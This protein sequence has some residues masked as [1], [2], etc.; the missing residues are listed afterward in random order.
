[1]LALPSEWIPGGWGWLGPVALVPVF[2]FTAR[3]GPWWSL[4]GG[5]AWI[6][7]VT[8]LAQSWL[9]SFHPLAF[10]LTLL[11]QIPW[12]A[13]VFAASSLL[14]RLPGGTWLQALL[15]TAFEY[16]RIQGFFAFPYGAVASAFW[17]W[18]VAFQT[19][20]LVGTSG[21]TL[22]LVWT[23]AWV[24]DTLSRIPAGKPPAWAGLAVGAV[25]WAADLGYGLWC[26]SRPDTG[27]AWRPALVQPSQ[28]PW[29]GGPAAYEAGFETLASLSRQALS[30]D[31]KPDAV[32][33]PET[34]FV[35][36][37]EYHT[38]YRDNPDSVRLVKRLETFLES[39][40]VPFV[41]GNDHREK[42]FDG[43]EADFNA[44]LAWD[45]G[46][47]GRYE[48][49]RLVPFTE[50]F[51]YK[52]SL[53]WVYRMLQQ[54]DTHFWEPGTQHNTLTVGGVV[55]G[56]PICFEDAFPDGARG[57]AQNGAQVLVN[58]TNDAWAPGVA[59][60]MQHL[61]LAV[62]R[63]VEARL[64]LVRAADDGATVAVSSRGELLAQLPVGPAGVLPASVKL[65]TGLSLY[66]QTGDWFAWTVSALVLVWAGWNLRPRVD[67]GE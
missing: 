10:P 2:W 60:R 48:K 24:A 62:F 36:S 5:V 7:L 39:S 34:A 66:T 49:N 58:L 28:D 56:T 46:W 35:P 16:L 18:P 6:T 32:I 4:V 41:L 40:S 31:P 59:S 42:T 52:K 1:V 23:S 44:V 43:S 8:G 57:F 14:W 45:H 63:S 67:K 27:T 37:V 38:K 13:A 25:L 53:P 17:A 3:Q 29:A 65:G 26:L 12:Y 19:A 51:P 30:L 64:P 55:V 15:W 47:K 20:D 21:L 11:F 9:L 54:A 50:S 61:S 22:L 33:W